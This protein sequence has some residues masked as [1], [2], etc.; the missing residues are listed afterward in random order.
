MMHQFKIKVITRVESILTIE[1]ESAGKAIEFI[2]G[3]DIMY[4]DGT[5][6]PKYMSYTDTQQSVSYELCND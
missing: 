3:N 5:A 6:N 1:A 2:R 4:P